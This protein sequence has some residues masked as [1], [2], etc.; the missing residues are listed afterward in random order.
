M[1]IDQHYKID[2]HGLTKEGKEGMLMD[3]FQPGSK[4]D[5]LPKMRSAEI[6]TQS[7]QFQL[8]VL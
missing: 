5:D 7:I 3:S 2:G 4:Q 8:F 6:L 1:S